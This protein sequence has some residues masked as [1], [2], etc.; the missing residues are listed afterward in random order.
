[1]VS[2]PGGAKSPLAELMR[3]P[4]FR[5]TPVAENRGFGDTEQFR[6]FADIHP[7]EE[8]AFHHDGMAWVQAR[9]FLHGSFE[10]QH[11]LLAG[12]RLAERLIE[13]DKRMACSAPLLRAP[14]S[15]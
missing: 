6:G 10:F 8:P 3:Q 15:G 11:V 13:C 2:Y 12:C 9:Q 4:G 14:A 7:P 1:M 5:H